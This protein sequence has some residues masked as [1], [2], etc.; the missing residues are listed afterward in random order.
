MVSLIIE[1]EMN[2]RERLIGR[3]QEYGIKIVA[4]DEAIARDMKELRNSSRLYSSDQ[5]EFFNPDEDQI[6]AM[7]VKRIIRE[8]AGLGIPFLSP[9]DYNSR[10]D[11]WLSNGSRLYLDYGALLEFASPE[12]RVGGLDIVIYEKASEIILNR[13]VKNILD[14]KVYKELSLYKNNTGPSGRNGIFPEITYGHHQ[15]YS[16]APGREQEIAN[17]LKTFI[18]ISLILSGSGHVHC[19]FNSNWRYL[20][21]PRATHIICEES[22]T[23]ISNRPLINSRERPHR[24]HLI[25]RD[26]TRCEFQTWLV[27]MVTHLVMR[28]AEEGWKMPDEFIFKDSISVLILSNHS[29]QNYLDDQ[30]GCWFLPNNVDILGYNRV[31]LK[32]AEQLNPLTEEEKDALEEW[33]RILELLSAKALDKLVGELDWVTKWNLIQ[34]Q[35]NKHGYGLNDLRAWKIDLS[36]HNIS[37]DP[38]Q[39]WFTRLDNLGYIR[40]LASNEDIQSAIVNPPTDTRAFSR[41]RLISLACRYKSLRNDIQGLDW[42]RVHIGASGMNFYSFG[43]KDNPFSPLSSELEK[44]YLEKYKIFP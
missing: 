3:E 22:N 1:H 35:M 39:S 8:F 2:M 36:Y 30:S 14:A 7:Q 26:A 11:L 37:N 17:I 43:E 44:L 31:F 40:H 34:N 12:C 38:D 15:N 29:F 6:R 16:Y 32:A 23:T 28:L 24:F 41:G 21:S 33:E 13:I 18:P 5:R 25:S 9:Y 27:D 42:G 10:S 19:D 20:I 4:D